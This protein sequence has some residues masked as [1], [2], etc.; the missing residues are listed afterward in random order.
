MKI[1]VAFKA[2][3]WSTKL[4]SKHVVHVSTCVVLVYTNDLLL[5]LCIL[6]LYQEH[7]TEDND[8]I[9]SYPIYHR[10]QYQPI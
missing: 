1:Y 5:C 4:L 7:M 6:W 3:L 8:A 9:Y 2:A 10:I